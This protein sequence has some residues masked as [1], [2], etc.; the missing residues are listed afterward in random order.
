MYQTHD[1]KVGRDVAIKILPEVF[2]HDPER[3]CRFQRETKTLASLNDPDIATIYG[4]EHS[5]GG[6]VPE[7]RQTD[8]L[9][10]GSC[11]REGHHPPPTTHLKITGSCGRS[12]QGSL[13]LIG[14]NQTFNTAS[15]AFRRSSDYTHQTSG[16][17]GNLV[18]TGP[19]T[20][21]S[22]EP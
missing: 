11:T 17:P 16:N 22:T 10:P 20:G 8:R 15:L 21:G 3:L 2:A 12:R 7:P 19:R 6:A 4:L 14:Y 1:T 5:N 9:G 13:S 18:I